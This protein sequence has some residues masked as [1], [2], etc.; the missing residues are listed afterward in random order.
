MSAARSRMTRNIDEFTYQAGVACAGTSRPATRSLRLREALDRSRRGDQ[1]AEYRSAQARPRVPLLMIG[2]RAEAAR[3]VPAVQP[4]VL[5]DAGC[6]RVDHRDGRRVVVCVLHRASSATGPRPYDRYGS[7]RQRLCAGRRAIPEILARHGVRLHLVQ[8]NGA[9]ENLEHLRDPSAEIGA[10]F[11]QAGTT[12]EQESPDLVSLVNVFYEPL[13][14]F[15]VADPR[16]PVAA[17]AGCAQSI[18]RPGSATRPLSVKLLTLAGVDTKNLSSRP[19]PPDEAARRLIAGELDMVV[20]FRHGNRPPC[21]C[22]CMRLASSSISFRRADAIVAREP[23][24]SK[25]VLP[26]GVVDFRTN[27]PP[28]DV[29]LIAG[30]ASLVVRK[31]LHPALQYL[32]LHAAIEVQSARHFSARG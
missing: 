28:A 5:Q 6:H 30:K 27:R 10:G 1:H 13:W 21:K 26:E 22:S 20:I 12:S 23:N 18:G 16:R 31:D 8:T 3:N 2:A 4:S 14:V 7:A 15:C 25:L 29:Q 32:L 17:A 11:V 19:V 9:V 24:F